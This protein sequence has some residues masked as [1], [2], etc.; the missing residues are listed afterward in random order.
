[1]QS[2]PGIWK[3]E[4]SFSASYIIT[5]SKKDCNQ[6]LADNWVRYAYGKN[7]QHILPLLHYILPL[8][9]SWTGMKACLRE[10][11]RK[12]T[13]LLSSGYATSR[14]ITWKPLKTSD[15]QGLWE[16]NAKHP[17][18]V[19]SS[20]GDAEVQLRFRITASTCLVS[21]SPAY[22]LE[23]P[24]ELS[25]NND[26]QTPLSETLI[27][28]VSQHG[29]LRTPPGFSSKYSGLRTIVGTDLT[30]VTVSMQLFIRI[31]LID[32]L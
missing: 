8:L 7:I 24:G 6:K 28:W 32:K 31:M 9:P 30:S 12:R 14:G 13:A 25:E 26:I 1:M 22:T 17:W 15:A 21:F 2:Q 16:Y 19:E 20:Q 3:C 29:C 27:P 11:S 4:W 5:S 10:W 23:L 18:I